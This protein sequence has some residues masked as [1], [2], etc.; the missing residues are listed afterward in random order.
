MHEISLEGVQKRGYLLGGPRAGWRRV[1]GAFSAHTALCT[2]H[3]V[4]AHMRGYFKSP[5]GALLVL[6]SCLTLT[7]LPGNC[8]EGWGEDRALGS[9]QSPCLGK[10]VAASVKPSWTLLPASIRHSLKSRTSDTVC[11]DSEQ[12]EN[13]GP[14]SK[15]ND[16]IQINN[17]RAPNPAQG[18][19]R[20]GPGPQGSHTCEATS[21]A[22]SSPTCGLRVRNVSVLFPGPSTEPG[23]R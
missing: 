7:Q 9:G 20:G 15:I 5:C 10:S 4:R 12:N 3:P 2:H 18:L 21:S 19:L 22:P 11:K 6:T 23:T 13:I 8:P 14:V 17:S 16:E 1:G